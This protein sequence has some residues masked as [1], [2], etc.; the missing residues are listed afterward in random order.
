[1]S[2]GGTA[3]SSPGRKSWGE[4]RETNQSRRACPELAERGRLKMTHDAILGYLYL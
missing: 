2:P 1:L 4:I 3:E